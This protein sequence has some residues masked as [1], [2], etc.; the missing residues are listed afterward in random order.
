MVMVCISPS[1]GVKFLARIP[2]VKNDAEYKNYYFMAEQHL[3]FFNIKNDG[4]FLVW[5]LIGN[6]FNSTAIFDDITIANRSITPAE[7]LA[8]YNSMDNAS[9]VVGGT[10]IPIDLLGSNVFW[11]GLSCFVNIEIQ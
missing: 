7:V 4:T 6:F 11:V 2:I 5:D 10:S 9:L 1:G 3:K 8:L